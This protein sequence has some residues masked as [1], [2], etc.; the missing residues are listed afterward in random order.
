MSILDKARAHY[1]LYQVNKY[2]KRREGHSEFKFKN[3]NYYHTNY[4]DG[5]YLEKPTLGSR[6][7]LVWTILTDVLKKRQHKKKVY[8]IN[9]K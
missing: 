4:R 6:K 2:T 9:N 7:T 8:D 5:V 1:D 3:K